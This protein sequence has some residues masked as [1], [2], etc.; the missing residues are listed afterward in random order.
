MDDLNISASDRTVVLPA[1]KAADEAATM[2][3]RCGNDGVFCGAAIQLHD[4]T[5]ITGKNSPLLHA[6]SSCIINAIKY[7][8][9]LP[10]E[11][12]LLSPQIIESV[13]KLKHDIFRDKQLS[14]ALSE[15]L[16][17]LSVSTP[18]NPAAALAM[19]Q[20]PSLAGCEMHLTHIPTQGDEAALRKLGI[21]ITSEPVF[22]SRNIFME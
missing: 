16:I 13:G 17:A 10:P 3:E 15:T 12:H 20:L 2:P 9:E 14:L 21:N 4:G 11:L 18:S 22:A 8:A 19:E 6:A 7:L 5:V 1:R